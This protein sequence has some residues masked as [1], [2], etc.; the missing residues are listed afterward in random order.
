MSDMID[1]TIV[2]VGPHGAG[3]T[4]LG[5]ALARRLGVPFHD[6]IG[7]RLAADASLRPAGTNASHCQP[8][9][10]EQ[11]FAEELARDTGWRGKGARV[12]ETWHPGNLAYAQARS[13]AQVRRFLPAILRAVQWHR[14]LVVPLAITGE[15]LRARQHE[16]APAD[17]F[18]RVGSAAHAWSWTLGLEVLPVLRTD[19]GTPE[20]LVTLLVRRLRGERPWRRAREGRS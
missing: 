15:T 19:F 18:L 9:Y 7:R 8:S 2:L 10:D 6:E 5:T 1:T 11:V 12:V 3:K 16:P 4:T 13:E 17:F 14:V 20:E